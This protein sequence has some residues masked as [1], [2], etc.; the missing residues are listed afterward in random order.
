MV[1]LDASR[2]KGPVLWL[3]AA[4]AVVMTGGIMLQD[5]LTAWR[6][7][8]AYYWT[9]SL[10]FS[11]HW[12]LFVPVF[13][14]TG[15]WLLAGGRAVTRVQLLAYTLA[16]MLI[17]MLAYAF[18]VWLV[19]MIFFDHSYGFM[20]NLGYALSTELVKYL[21][22]YAVLFVYLHLNLAAPTPANSRT[23]PGEPAAPATHIEVSDHRATTLVAV[24]DILYV[25]TADP[26]I[27]LHTASRKYLLLQSLAA[28]MA[29]LDPGF[30][31]VHRSVIVNLRALRKWTSRGNGDYDLHMA[32]GT[33]LRLSRNYLRQFREQMEKLPTA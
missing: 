9:E 16:A 7:A 25:Q 15:R 12:L 31:R 28:I 30:V 26:Y 18:M 17:H 32:D 29:Q 13:M 6:T 5:L 8:G 23:A 4:G 21:L 27:A 10:L 22:V 11:I 1:T 33:V 19:S 3:V 24:K 14:L 2:V 20:G